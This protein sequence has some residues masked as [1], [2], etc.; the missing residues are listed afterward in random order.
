M[1]LFPESLLQMNKWTKPPPLQDLLLSSLFKDDYKRTV[2]SMFIE[3]M[4]LKAPD[5][6]ALYIWKI[7]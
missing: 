1:L 4:I 7:N 3:A 2:Y 6:K 5:V